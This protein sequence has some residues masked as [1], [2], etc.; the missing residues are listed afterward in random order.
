MN[1]GALFVVGS[2][3]TDSPSHSRDVI[4]CG[5]HTNAPTGQVQAAGGWVRFPTMHTHIASLVQTKEAPNAASLTH[6]CDCLGAQ[7]HSW[8]RLRLVAVSLSCA[9]CLRVF[10]SWLCCSWVGG[11]SCPLLESACHVLCPRVS[12]MDQ[13]AGATASSTSNHRCAPFH[14][15]TVHHLACIGLAMRA[16]LLVQ[17]ANLAMS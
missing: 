6:A 1:V 17:E 11:L 12:F 4:I 15:Y 16:Q 9:R 13:S 14:A 8:W 7:G 10:L 5:V 3:W 2:L